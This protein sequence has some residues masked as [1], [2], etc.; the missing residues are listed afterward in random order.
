MASSVGV[1][2]DEVSSVSQE[3]H[4]SDNE[5]KAVNNAAAAF[6]TPDNLFDD[7]Q[8]T[9]QEEDSEVTETVDQEAPEEVQVSPEEVEQ[10]NQQEKGSRAKARIQ[11][12]VAEKKKTQE[13]F[14]A[15]RA[16]IAERDQKL[17]A[18]LR[19]VEATNNQRTAE[20]QA[21][22][23]A[24]K[25]REE[26]LR[27]FG[28]KK[29]LSAVEQYEKELE[30]K[31]MK[32]HQDLLE[33]KLSPLQKQLQEEQE[34]RKRQQETLK[35]RQRYDYYTS[36]AAKVRDEY[37]FKGVDQEF[38]KEF[39]EQAQDW[40]LTHSAAFGEDPSEAGKKLKIFLDKY[41][42]QQLRAATNKGANLKQAKP[43]ADSLSDVPTKKYAPT[44]APSRDDLLAN[45]FS[46]PFHWRVA[47]SPP[48]KKRAQKG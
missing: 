4:S 48:L 22:L 43:A 41:H 25:A 23:A 37:V 11:N 16:Q 38:A 18:Y 32:K 10:D 26:T 34:N 30:Q 28:P 35:K 47:G 27:E 33:E 46:T 5:A 40:I 19:Q 31:F 1:I 39:A 15:Y 45:G 8:P 13:E 2:E 17:A 29:E 36:Q 6:L 3:T 44:A 24:L 20:L 12:L 14:A 7:E 21:Q 9:Q 42:Q